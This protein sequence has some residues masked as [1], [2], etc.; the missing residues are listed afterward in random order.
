M[1][2]RRGQV[3]A[4]GELWGQ[5]QFFSKPLLV[6][7]TI[8]C[9]CEDIAPGHIY[10]G[11]KGKGIALL[12]STVHCADLKF[13]GRLSLAVALNLVGA[14]R[15]QIETRS[16]TIFHCGDATCSGDSFLEWSHN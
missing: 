2:L 10:E 13:G 5:K 12:Q 3:V 4:R 14:P 9:L 1:V 16:M 7:S 15:S 11:A 8:T 6:M